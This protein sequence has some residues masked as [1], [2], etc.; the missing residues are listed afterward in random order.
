MVT[1]TGTATTLRPSPDADG[2]LVVRG[3]DGRRLGWYD[4][5][6]GATRLLDPAPGAA[7][8]VQ[9]AVDSWVAATS[10]LR[11]PV[12]SFARAVPAPRGPLAD[13]VPPTARR[14]DPD[15]V[16][17][18]LHD[19]LPGEHLA[20]ALAARAA[21]VPRAPRR[22]ATGR[23]P[24]GP[25]LRHTHQALLGQQQVGAAL[26][27]AGGGWHVLHAVPT[28]GREWLDHLLVGP[29]GV[30][31]L[32]TAAH[33]G[34]DLRIAGSLARAGGRPVTHVRLLAR[35][36][37]AVAHA[38]RE[39]DARSTRAP[40]P[41]RGV[42]V[43]VG[44]RAVRARGLPAGVEVVRVEHLRAWL[45]GLPTVLAQA[46]VHRLAATAARRS[47]WPAE[48]GAP[49]GAAARLRRREED[50]AA[51]ELLGARAR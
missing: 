51:V 35:Q 4:L 7:A 5:R 2:R 36:T 34:E 43:A 47:T 20:R 9:A 3:T 42:V 15:A 26:V 50:R 6:T 10:A 29:G 16:P 30:V 41:V 37:A 13:A 31:V 25:A 24:L 18:D 44:T 45:R 27:G 28:A 1:A 40:V 21:A 38:L 19:R 14:P 32:R 22:P 17:E 46:D 8:E 11:R 33:P 49:A 39:A 12:A 48:D 23:D